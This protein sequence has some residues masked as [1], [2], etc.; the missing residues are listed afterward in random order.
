MTVV[1][2]RRQIGSTRDHSRRGSTTNAIALLA[3][4]GPANQ[5]DEAR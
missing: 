4:Q 5:P 2:E 1:E 3:P